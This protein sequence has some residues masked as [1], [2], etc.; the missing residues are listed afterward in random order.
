MKLSASKAAKEAG[1]SIPTITRAIEKGR[2]S[3]EK[4]EDSKGSKGYL[5]DP[6]ELFRVF[7]PK[8]KPSNDHPNETPAILGTETPNETGVLQV[9]IKMLRE[10]L[11]DKDAVIDDLRH[12]LDDE[13]A[14]RRKLTALLTDQTVRPAPPEVADRPK[15]SWWPFGKAND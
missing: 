1:V 13:A 9:E 12:R 10:R 2:L 7:P 3:A 4:T 15:R 11:E 8:P 14:E 5:I 6:A